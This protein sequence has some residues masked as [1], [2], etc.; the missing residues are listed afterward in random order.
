MYINTNFMN[1]F[2]IDALESDEC[3]AMYQICLH[4]GANLFGLRA[5]DCYYI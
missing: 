4:F 2:I 5:Q 1:D 3:E